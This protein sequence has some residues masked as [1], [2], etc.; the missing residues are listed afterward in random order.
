MNW[1]N[2]RG[3]S[4]VMSIRNE[5]LYLILCVLKCVFLR[6]DNM[7][8]LLILMCC[9][10]S[11]LR[12]RKFALL[13]PSNYVYDYSGSE[14]CSPPALTSRLTWSVSGRT[15]TFGSGSNREDKL[16]TPVNSGPDPCLPEICDKMLVRPA[17]S[18]VR[19]LIYLLSNADVVHVWMTPG[20]MENG[21]CSA[22]SSMTS[23]TILSSSGLFYFL[24]S[25]PGQHC[26]SLTLSLALLN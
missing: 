20:S 17:L 1:T 8:V 21:I 13:S 19:V 2:F 5:S 11:E 18:W 10:P 16:E 6:V 24:Y 7:N 3:H 26:H 12:S 23:S 9:Q 25:P 15:S 14:R 4:A 22:R